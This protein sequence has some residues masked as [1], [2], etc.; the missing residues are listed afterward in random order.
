MKKTYEIFYPIQAYSQKQLS[1]V[2]VSKIELKR[3]VYSPIRQILAEYE[4]SFKN[5]Q[6]DIRACYEKRNQLKLLQK[7]SPS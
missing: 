5:L 7:E 3:L 2:G 6:T 1:S 4:L